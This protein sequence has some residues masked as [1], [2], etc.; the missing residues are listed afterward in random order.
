[1]SKVAFKIA[2]S[3][4]VLGLVLGGCSTDRSSMFRTAAA[5]PQ[6]AR[7]DQRASRYFELAQQSAAAGDT[8]GA[9]A[10]AEKAVELSPR[11]AGY[12]MLL[13][14]LYLKNGRFQSAQT[15][16]MDVLTL[17]P[18]NSRATFNLVLA[19]IAL[20]RP[21]SALIKLDRLAETAA[22]ADV[23]LAYALAG[24]PDRAV[25]MLEGAARAPGADGRVRQNLALSYALAGNWQRA[26]V[27]AAQDLSPAELASRMEQWA[28][29]VQPAAQ[30]DQVATLLGVTP[31]DDAGQPVRLALAPVAPAEAVYAQAE[32][33]PVVEAPP[34]QPIQYAAAAVP[35]PVTQ[36]EYIPAVEAVSTPQRGV[37]P[38]PVAAPAF[39]PAAV[40]KVAQ[41]VSAGTG[42]YVVQLGSYGSSA[43]LQQGW[44][45]L[46]KR[47][48]LSGT[49]APLTAVVDLPGKGR[50]HRL[51]V[52]GFGTQAEA[53]RACAA[54][55]SKGGACFV[56]GKAGDAPVQWASRNSRKG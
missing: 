8:A 15:T 20:G 16:F 32:A 54:I 34:A 41:E 36:P 2:A 17:H 53:A 44:S 29:F 3:P 12:R 23:G 14:D 10:Q 9:V 49:Y 30:W 43:A 22:P 38:A 6:V 51:S 33:R 48:G 13:G 4:L 46:Q 39:R 45:Q 31:A 56:R 35:L 21:H 19:E 47:Y 55:K 28:T 25:T 50:F 7:A 42:R 26:K 11:D 18:G 5:S 1:M 24:Y 52:A 37:E 40:K 27:T